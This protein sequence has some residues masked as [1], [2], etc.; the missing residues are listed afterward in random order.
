MQNIYHCSIIGIR[1]RIFI[2]IKLVIKVD[3]AFDFQRFVVHT[4]FDNSI[5]SIHP[6][7]DR[8][9]RSIHSSSD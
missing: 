1:S 2:H 7:I 6:S 9:C 4:E 3:N 8:I 5:Q